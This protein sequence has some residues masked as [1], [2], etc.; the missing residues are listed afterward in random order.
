MGSSAAWHV[1]SAPELLSAEQVLGEAQ[2]SAM[3]IK[4]VLSLG[5][6]MV[7]DGD[8]G[9]LPL[10]VSLN[11]KDVSFSEASQFKICCGS[12]FGCQAS[13]SGE[14]S[15]QSVCFKMIFRSTVAYKEQGISH[16]ALA[17]S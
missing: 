7:Q 15:E 3:G 17:D 13:S 1:V 4:A 8:E 11:S 9:E 5:S 6:F 14:V 12:G 10:L 2:A 16:W